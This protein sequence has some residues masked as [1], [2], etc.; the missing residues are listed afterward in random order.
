MM[1]WKQLLSPMRIRQMY[2]GG[3]STKV[4]EDPRTEFERD[5]GRT[6][7]STP[8]RRLQD[9]AQV[10]PLERH[11]AVRTRLTHSNEV[12]SVA[13]G[14]AGAAAE[15]MLKENLLK[16]SSYVPAITAI[17]AT[18]GLIHDLGNPPFGHSGEVAIANWFQGKLETDGTFFDDLGQGDSKPAETQFAQDFLRFE[19]NAQTQRLLSKLQILADEFGLNLT[20]GTLSASCKYIARSNEI[21]S[22]LHDCSKHGFFASENDLIDKVR[23]ETGTFRARNPITYL[24]EASD[25]IVYSTVDLEDGVKKGVVTW[26]MVESE[27]PKHVGSE[28]PPLERALAKAHEKIDKAKLTERAKDEAMSQAFR[29]FAILEGVHAVLEAYKQN[30]GKIMAGDY[31]REL[32]KDSAAAGLIAACK[33]VGRDHVYV[34]DETLKLEIQGCQVIHDLLNLFWKGAREYR[35]KAKLTRFSAKIYKLAS[36]NYRTVFENNL[37][38]SAST[39]IPEMYF[40]LQLVTDHISGMTDTYACTLHKSLTNG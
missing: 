32:L 31:H 7:F 39:G 23:K 10:F 16:V 26:K 13:R 4:D 21:D 33:K 1:D 3:G 38:S 5:Y 9:K 30:Y 29:T 19:G 8:V 37:S 36:E 18:C 14:L 20:C 17:A 15:W 25:D 27:L 12:S 40:R 24:V 22:S 2:E 6:I 35:P 28:S 11:D 34:S